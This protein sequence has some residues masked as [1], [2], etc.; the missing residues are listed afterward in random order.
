MKT[1]VL[2]IL[3][4][5]CSTFSHAMTLD[6]GECQETAQGFIA[7]G[8]TSATH[9]GAR[10][11]DLKKISQTVSKNNGE[12]VNKTFNQAL[13]ESK[14]Y[15]L[16]IK[17]KYHCPHEGSSQCESVI[18]NM[19]YINNMENIFDKYPKCELNASGHTTANTL[20]EDTFH[21]VGH[22]PGVNSPVGACDHIPAGDRK[23]AFDKHST[24]TVVSSAIGGCLVGFIKGFFNN[25]KDVVTSLWSLLELGQ[26]L[27]AKFGM[28]IV[29]FL[30]AAWYGTTGTFFAELTAQG[31]QFFKDVMNTFKSLPEALYNALSNGISDFNCLNGPAKTAAICKAAGYIAPEVLLAIFTGG[32]GNAAKASAEAASTAISLVKKADKATDIVKV[33]DRASDASKLGKAGKARGKVGDFRKIL[34]DLGHNLDFPTPSEYFKTGSTYQKDDVIKYLKKLGADESIVSEPKRFK[35]WCVRKAAQL[36]PDRFSY[37][38]K[39]NINAAADFEFK[40]F[41]NI[42]NVIGN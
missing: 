12:C 34:S 17:E 26:K 9:P 15:W 20:A 4:M 1:V 3:L 7:K 2:S 28:M 23:G 25:I 22:L 6:L 29:N 13:E 19:S 5:I 41:M 35:K 40:N 39:S 33:A 42:C 14:E 27:A 24:T 10:L 31:S 30:K 21:I 8:S 18:I 32:T 38:N 16:H 11:W 36:H 37:L